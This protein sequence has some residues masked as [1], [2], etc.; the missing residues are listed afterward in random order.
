MPDFFLQFF[1]NLFFILVMVNYMKRRFKAKKRKN[2]SFLAW[3]ILLIAVL[4]TTRLILH[5]YKIEN[6]AN[7]KPIVFKVNPNKILM[8]MGLNYMY[9]EQV[10]ENV[11]ETFNEVTTTTTKVVEIKPKIYIYNTHQTENYKDYDVY[12]ASKSLKRSLENKGVDVI[13]ET[14]NIKDA[15]NKEKLTFK[16]SYKITR[17]LLE[18]NI[19]NKISLY[20]D[21][22][23]DSIK[24]KLTTTNY[25]DK[26]VAKMMFVVG[27][28]H[29]NYKQNYNIVKE[30]N[31]MLKNINPDLSRGIFVRKNSSFNQD[32]NKNIILIELGGIENNKE[33]VNNA[34]EHLSNVI[35][36]YV[37]E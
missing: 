28:K 17:K 24:H 21:L 6:I 31:K 33:E 37:L 3:I 19:N 15:L 29:N 16:D 7:K 9:K 34:I 2:I 10:K 14:T 30:L 11:K 26:S 8:G 12:Q 1:Y 25:N 32:L 22:H 35:S 13:V 20:I 5:H 36:N 27:G 4:F 23:R 18:K